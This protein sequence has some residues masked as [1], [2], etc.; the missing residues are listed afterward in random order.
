MSM[1]K[2]LQ[3]HHRIKYHAAPTYLLLR[4]T[5]IKFVSINLNELYAPSINHRDF[6]VIAEPLFRI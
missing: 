3:A 5:N 2:L 1:F 6:S 4:L